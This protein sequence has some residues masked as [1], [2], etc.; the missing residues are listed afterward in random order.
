MIVD[1]C[2]SRRQRLG[3]LAVKIGWQVSASADFAQLETYWPVT[4]VLAVHD[5]ADLVAATFAK[6]VKLGRWLPLVVY[7]AD[8]EPARI[9]DV[10]RVGANDY[11]EWPISEVDLRHR[12]PTNDKAGNTMAQ[13]RRLTL[14]SEL[15]IAKLT[16]RERQVLASLPRGDSNK[17][18]ARR[19]NLS[20]RTVEIHRAH[21]MGKLG[22]RSVA[23]AIS[24]AFYAG[25]AAEQDD[26]ELFDPFIASHYADP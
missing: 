22:A 12:L 4:G 19:F 5:E 21:M 11:F 23:Q 26:D 20:P 18:I 2:P 3:S 17:E 1:S 10:V 6:M 8:P 13:L 25:L 14:R 15:L 16:P 7:A 9:V 24:I